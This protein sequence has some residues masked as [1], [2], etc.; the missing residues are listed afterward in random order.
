MRATRIAHAL[1]TGALALPPVG[2]I[3]VFGPASPEDLAPLPARR[4]ICVTGFAP[5]HDRLSASGLHVVR[6]ATEQAALALVCLP[7]GR[8]HARALVAAAAAVVGPRGPVVIDGQ[9]EDGVETMQRDIA[10][11]GYGPADVVAKA[12]GRLFSF[13]APEAGQLA[14]WEGRTRSVAGGF[15]TGPGVFSADGPDPGSALLAAS[16]PDRLPARMADL[17]AGWGWLAAQVL[18]HPGVAQI[19]LI[20][21]EADALDCARINVT[22]ARARFIWADATRHLPPAPY[23]GIVCNPPFH[24]ARAADPALGAAFIGAASRMIAPAGVL[25]LVANRHLPYEEVLRSDFAEVETIALEGGYR[26]WRAARPARGRTR[27]ASGAGTGAVR[28]GR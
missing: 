25:W 8:E 20:E 10:R 4:L 17:G 11:R 22:D 1:E 26:V 6:Q 21:A 5:D 19:D 2:Q 12:H 14:D 24:R 7:R 16:L 27:A 18:H 28:R 9:K 23:D 3:V 15:V 13:A